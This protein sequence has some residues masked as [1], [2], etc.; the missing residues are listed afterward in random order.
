MLNNYRA[1]TRAQEILCAI[2]MGTACSHFCRKEY[3]MQLIGQFVNHTLFGKGVVTAW[4]DT[5][6]TVRFSGGEK[7]FIF[8]DAFSG[9]LTL[10]NTAAKKYI[11]K[12]IDDRTAEKED[13]LKVL[14]EAQERKS[15]LE[16]LTFSSQSQAVFDISAEQVESVF[17]SWAVSTGSYL[18][19]YSVG[20]PRIPERMTPNSM[21]LLTERPAQ[22]PEAK[23][24][25]I[26]AFMVEEDFIGN[27]CRNGIIQ[28]HPDYRLRIPHDQ[29]PLFW[30][31]IVQRPERQ[32]WGN[33]TFKYMSNRAGEEVLFALKTLPLEEKSGEC[34]EAFYQYYCKLNRI[35]PRDRDEHK[36]ADDS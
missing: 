17:S 15:R 18:S 16:N 4:T 30:P 7:R 35:G 21:C 1:I 11:Q 6:I 20:E 3:D 25:I 33:T 2:R 23:R 27:Y 14:F 24:R 36:A 9:F 13:K 22:Q 12:L 8:P 19:G 34:A 32:R 31:Y 5:T 26:G 29:Q 28:A 10:K